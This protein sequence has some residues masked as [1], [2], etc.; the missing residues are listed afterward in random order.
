MTDSES[1]DLGELAKKPHPK[2]ARRFLSDKADEMRRDQIVSVK[3]LFDRAILLGQIDRRANGGDQREIIRVARDADRNR[4]RV[5][6]S[7]GS[8]AVHLQNSLLRRLTPASSMRSDSRA[9]GS[10][11]VR[12]E[13]WGLV[14]TRVRSLNCVR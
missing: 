2:A 8:T 7:R 4:A 11:R 3:L 14:R 10:A 1:F 6:V 13:N 9:V 5:R 12:A